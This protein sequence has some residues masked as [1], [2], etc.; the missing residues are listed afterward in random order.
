MTHPI[1][2]NSEVLNI[3]Q[4]FSEKKMEYLIKGIKKQPYD[5]M[6]EIENEN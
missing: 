1:F 2:H 3:L 5:I 4:K 6:E